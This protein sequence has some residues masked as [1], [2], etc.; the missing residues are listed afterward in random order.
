MFQGFRPVVPL[1]LIWYHVYNVVPVNESSQAEITVGRGEGGHWNRV[2]DITIGVITTY[3]KKQ[4]FSWVWELLELVV[5]C[6]SS[7][8]TE[9]RDTSNCLY[10]TGPKAPCTDLWAVVCFLSYKLF[11]ISRATE[12]T[13]G[14]TSIC[15]THLSGMGFYQP[16]SSKSGLT[17][18]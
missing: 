12:Q 2:A 18:P 13:D 11:Y 10:W 5:S 1:C 9:W 15:V 8:Q 3:C 4:W 17:Q 7:S 16:P 14:G 6:R